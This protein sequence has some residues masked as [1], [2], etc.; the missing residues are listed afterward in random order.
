MNEKRYSY[1]NCVRCAFSRVVR[2]VRSRRIA[3]AAVTAAASASTVD[4]V[5]P[6][7]VR[8]VRMPRVKPSHACGGSSGDTCGGGSGFCQLAVAVMAGRREGVGWWPS[9]G[10]LSRGLG[11]ENGRARVSTSGRAPPPTRSVSVRVP[12]APARHDV[13]CLLIVLIYY[14]TGDAIY[15]LLMCIFL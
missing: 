6:R 3:Q 1:R 11:R 15:S 12:P 10:V 7:F 4:R 2:Q 13:R 5:R 8:A 14:Y 9:G